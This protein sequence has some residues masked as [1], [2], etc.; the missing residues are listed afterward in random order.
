MLFRS[1]ELSRKN[2]DSFFLCLFLSS[3]ISRHTDSNGGSAITEDSG[4][5]PA[6]RCSAKDKHIHIRY[7]RGVTRRP[8][9]SFVCERLNAIIEELGGEKIDLVEYSEDPAKFISAS[10]APARV[11][12]VE[13]NEETPNTCKVTVPDNQLSLAIGNK[14]QNVRLAARLTGYKIDIHPES[15]FYGEAQ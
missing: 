11:L 14:G 12:N 13:F 2:T 8:C 3:V 15:G 1:G 6:L 4:E 5:D 9:I 10:L 7:P